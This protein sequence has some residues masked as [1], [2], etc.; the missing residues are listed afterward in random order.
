MT[1]VPRGSSRMIAPASEDFPQP[2]SPASPSVS[3][4]ARSKLTPRTAGTWP[5]PVR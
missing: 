1:S 3:P 5:L 2:D 4:A